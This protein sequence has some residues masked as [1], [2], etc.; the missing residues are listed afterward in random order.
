MY[1]ECIYILQ[2]LHFLKYITQFFILSVNKP[3]HSTVLHLA[4]GLD[5][6]IAK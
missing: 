2:F 1:L 4:N 3:E 5:K 6:L